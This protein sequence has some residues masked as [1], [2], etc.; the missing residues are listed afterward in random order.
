MKARQPGTTL[1]NPLS[2]CQSSDHRAEHRHFKALSPYCVLKRKL[3]DSCLGDSITTTPAKKPYIPS[4]ASPDLGL[5]CDSFDVVIPETVSQQGPLD[6]QEA[7]RRQTLALEGVKSHLNLSAYSETSDESPPNPVST[8][9]SRPLSS[10]NVNRGNVFDFN[11][12]NILCLSPITCDAGPATGATSDVEG[13]LCY[14]SHSPLALDATAG[15]QMGVGERGEQPSANRT[16]EGNRASNSSAAAVQ[17]NGGH[18][19]H[20]PLQFL[21]EGG[22]SSQPLL[23]PLKL[24]KV[25]AASLKANQDLKEVLATISSPSGPS[26]AVVEALEVKVEMGCGA[27]LFESTIC[28]TGEEH[29][30][31]SSFEDSLPLEVQVG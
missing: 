2:Y 19:S 24:R 9:N 4:T 5:G 28:E 17:V 15:Q 25:H 12:D 14:R 29:T 11:I 7:A 6:R 16:S 1:F 8:T 20:G 27:P 18:L 31:E 30:V 13:C 10:Y 21:S 26:Q 3:D 23:K 22:G